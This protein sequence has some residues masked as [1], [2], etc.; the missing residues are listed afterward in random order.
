MVTI[1]AEANGL[2]DS[3]NL[4]PLTFDLMVMMASPACEV[5]EIDITIDPLTVYYIGDELMP[6]QATVN[7]SVK[8]VNCPVQCQLTQENFA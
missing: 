3:G 8:S 5:D 2:M 4:S 7:Q 6:I 1:R